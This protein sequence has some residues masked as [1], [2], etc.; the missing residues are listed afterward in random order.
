MKS[1]LGVLVIALFF[2]CSQTQETENQA[3]EKEVANIPGFFEGKA[4]FEA[5]CVR[6]HQKSGEPNIKLYPPLKGSDYLQANQPKIAC[7][8]RNGVDE[9]LIVNGKEYKIK[10]QGFPEL[11]AQE[12]SQ[13]IN[14]INNSW[15]NDF[16]KT[17]VEKVKTSLDGCAK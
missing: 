13:I 17:D 6:C 4:L 1:V 5:N 3:Q 8:I 11:T 12:I 10:M 2:S 16:G 9:D 15:G 7:I 14:Y